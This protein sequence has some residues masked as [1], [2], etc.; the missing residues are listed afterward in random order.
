MTIATGL[1][2]SE[3]PL[4]V[5]KSPASY[6]HSLKSCTYFSNGITSPK[7]VWLLMAIL[8]N[9]WLERDCSFDIATWRMFDLS[10]IVHLIFL[11]PAFMT[12]ERHSCPLPPQETL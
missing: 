4:F 9:V 10:T 12:P 8:G 6:E 2:K 5:R 1:S 3:S 11:P 7:V